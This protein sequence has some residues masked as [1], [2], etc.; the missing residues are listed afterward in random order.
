[1]RAFRGVFVLVLALALSAPVSAADFQAGVAADDRGDYATALKEYRPLAEQGHAG[2]QTNLGWMYAYGLGVP[3]DYAEAAKWYRLAAEQGHRRAQLLLGMKL[4]HGQGVPQDY[5]E[6]MKWYRLAAEQ[7]SLTAMLYLGYMLRDGEGVAQ[8][9][10]LAHM[11][12]NLVA[13][14]RARCLTPLSRNRGKAPPRYPAAHDA[15]TDRR[16]ATPRE[17]MEAE[18]AAVRRPDFSDP[19]GPPADPTPSE[20]ASAIEWIPVPECPPTRLASERRPGADRGPVPSGST[21]TPKPRAGPHFRVPQIRARQGPAQRA[22]R[23]GLEA[24]ERRPE[25]DLEP[26]PPEGVRAICQ[27]YCDSHLPCLGGSKHSLEI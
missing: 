12:F 17:G 26:T 21:S 27:C 19:M 5:A 23:P 14:K 15:R 1:M 20:P 8:N 13:G 10:V 4:K 9:Y 24:A 3:Q 11:W 25:S 18:V 22:R 16:G 6:A 2:A 7:G